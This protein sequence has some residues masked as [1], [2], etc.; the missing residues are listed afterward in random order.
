MIG[1]LMTTYNQLAD[2]RNALASLKETTAEPLGLVIVDNASTDG[3]VQYARQNGY[4]VIE[5]VRPVSLSTAINQGLT[6]LLSIPDVRYIGWIHNDMTFYP[7]WLPRLV[8]ELEA[9]PQIGKLA[10]ES[11]HPHGPDLA[12][13]AEQFMREH[14]SERYPGN[15]C[16]WIMPRAVIE[17]AGLFDERFIQC[18]GYEDWDYNNRIIELG[19]RVMITRGSVV[20][21]PAMGTRKHQD[22][23]E[24]GRHNA[25]V[26]YEKWGTNFPKV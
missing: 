23:L 7:R 1:L 3:T 24:S 13:A 21:H 10:P 14:Q 20:W 6:Y 4:P 12:D 8:Q 11:F 18:G 16:P 9:E 25:G 5:N 22:E 26:Y 19:Y 17:K 15:A 2:T